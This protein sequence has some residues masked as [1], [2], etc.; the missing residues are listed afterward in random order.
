M[1]NLDPLV[2]SSI[3]HVLGFMF[4]VAD[5]MRFNRH[6]KP[7]TIQK[8]WFLV[9]TADL[10]SPK[11]HDVPKF[12]AHGSHTYLSECAGEIKVFRRPVCGM[13]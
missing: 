6:L 8:R 13:D 4:Q 12:H 10:L 1:I 9:K 5:I 11:N 3:D 7:K 2:R